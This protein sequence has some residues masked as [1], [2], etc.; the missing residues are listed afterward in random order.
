MVKLNN[1][2]RNEI[3]CLLFFKPSWVNYEELTDNDIIRYFE[4]SEQGLHKKDID[5]YAIDG[6]NCLVQCKRW[7][8]INCH[9]L[10]EPGVLDG[11]VPFYSLLQG[12]PAY[13]VDYLSNELFK[14]HSK[15]IILETYKEIQNDNN[16]VSLLK[17][18]KN[19]EMIN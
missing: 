16:Y 2:R 12:M 15:D 10:Y 19:I 11:S 4:W 9:E 17:S 8:G 18:H 5:S 14:G 1:K 3:E 7:R 13:I 6:F